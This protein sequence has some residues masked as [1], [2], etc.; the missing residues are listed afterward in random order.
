[1]RFMRHTIALAAVVVSTLTLAD[2]PSG[3]H[4]KTTGDLVELCSVSGDDP[5]FAAAMGFCLGYIDATLDYHESLTLGAKYGP[6]AC[7]HTE[8]TRKEVVTV[9][10]DWA[11]HNPQYLK[12]EAPV[13]G[14]MRALFEKWPCSGR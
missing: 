13:Q 2:T 4:I 10:L 9:F 5:S 14:V 11:K 12:T 8:V 7:P 6:I 3:R 1:M